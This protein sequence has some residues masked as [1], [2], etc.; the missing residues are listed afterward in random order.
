M[1]TRPSLILLSLLTFVSAGCGGPGGEPAP[2]P[3]PTVSPNATATPPVPPPPS[4]QAKTPTP[5]KSPT[6]LKAIGLIPSTPP[7]QRRKEI[8]AGRNNP[9]ALMGI[10]VLVDPKAIPSDTSSGEPGTPGEPGK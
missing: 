4:P 8:I 3:S 1:K 5:Q 6:N 7:D 10:N 9:F 2:S